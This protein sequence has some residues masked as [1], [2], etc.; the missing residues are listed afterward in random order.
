MLDEFFMLEAEGSGS[1]TGHASHGIN[2]E[3]TM[4]EQIRRSVAFLVKLVEQKKYRTALDQ[5]YDLRVLLAD[6]IGRNTLPLKH[7]GV[8]ERCQ[9]REDLRMLLAWIPE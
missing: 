5:L 4:E 8:D 1:V 9:F 2:E 7:L 3:F 6:K